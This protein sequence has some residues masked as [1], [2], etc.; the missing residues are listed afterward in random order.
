[1]PHKCFLP[2]L[3]M[4]TVGHA[5]AELKLTGCEIIHPTGLI[6]AVTNTKIP[7]DNVPLGAKIQFVFSENVFRNTEEYRPVLVMKVDSAG[8]L[9][10]D[11]VLVPVEV[12]GNTVTLDMSKVRLERMDF[13]FIPDEDYLKSDSTSYRVFVPWNFVQ[14]ETKEGLDRNYGFSLKRLSSGMGKRLTSLLKLP[15]MGMISN[16]S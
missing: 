11:P 2:L 1:M 4:L 16:I 5:A 12:D 8:V 9:Q 15:R 14:T 13:D 3:C 6:V 10:E 7:M